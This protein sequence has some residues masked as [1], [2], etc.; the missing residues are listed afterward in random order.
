MNTPAFITFTGIDNATDLRAAKELASQYP[1]EFGILFSTDRQGV[2]LR[3]PSWGTIYRICDWFLPKLAAH[4][5]GGYA[6]QLLASARTD[7]DELLLDNF[8]RVQ[9][10]TA[11]RGIDT[12]ALSEWG[13]SVKAQP[14]L[15]CR[16]SSF[17]EDQQVLWLFDASGGKGVEPSAWPVAATELQRPPFVGFAG[18]ISPS[19]IARLLPAIA[20]SAGSSPYWIDMESGV[21]DEQDRF[22][23]GKC[24]AVCEAVYGRKEGGAA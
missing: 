24:R 9:V 11:Q 4:L 3:Y 23:L 14:I 15:Q 1:V 12:A 5:C 10:N 22:D 6:R 7:L 19:N 20:Q 17:P 13:D 18:G 8:S 21:R 2:D 16:G